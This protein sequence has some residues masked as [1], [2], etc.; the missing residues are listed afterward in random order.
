MSSNRHLISSECTTD[1]VH[2]RDLLG[3]AQDDFA[4]LLSAPT[5]MLHNTML[6]VKWHLWTY[7]VTSQVDISEA[8][9][10]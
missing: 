5:M 6:S 3:G 1:L 8:K 7:I 2:K 9:G 4:C 10:L